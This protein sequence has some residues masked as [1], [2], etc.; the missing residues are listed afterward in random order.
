MEALRCQSVDARR[1]TFAAMRLQN[2][3]PTSRVS[4]SGTVEHPS[5]EA[6]VG[7]TALEE[8]QIARAA[9][10]AA[11]KRSNVEA[12]KRAEALAAEKHAEREKAEK[13]T[14]E[15]RAKGAAATHRLKEV[16]A[17]NLEKSR[18]EKQQLASGKAAP[19]AVIAGRRSAEAAPAAQ[20]IVATS[21]VQ[22][23]K[24]RRLTEAQERKSRVA[25][26]KLATAA[27][28]L[29]ASS[30]AAAKAQRIADVAAQSAAAKVAAAPA[31]RVIR[32]TPECPEWIHD[33]AGHFRENDELGL[34]WEGCVN[35][36]VLFEIAMGFADCVRL[37]FCLLRL[38]Q[39]TG[40]SHRAH[41]ERLNV[42]KR[43]LRG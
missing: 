32:L 19:A 28:K 34:E 2:A 5:A 27:I 20:V 37:S 24:E 31:G 14:T 3:G 22:D 15:A 18:V 41:T 38:L 1:A 6:P 30:D 29:K 13:R 43:L 17:M 23:E 33:T 7:A 25:A 9:R 26:K 40:G 21:L 4:E 10:M 11:A 16:A 35:A 42:Q 36:W 39:L 8:G 12:V